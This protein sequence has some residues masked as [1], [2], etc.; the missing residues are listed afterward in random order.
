LRLALGWR[1]GARRLSVVVAIA[2]WAASQPACPSPELPAV[3]RGQRRRRA[4]LR[5]VVPFGNLLSGQ[6]TPGDDQRERRA[7]LGHRAGRV[8]AAGVP[9]C[10]RAAVRAR[11]ARVR[12][13][14]AFALRLGLAVLGLIVVEQLYRR[15]DR[16]AR[17]ALK[18]LC[19]AVAGIFAFDLYYFADAMLFGRLDIDIWMG[20]GL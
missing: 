12:R 10:P 17:W 1:A 18:P 5:D 15:A 11:R 2:L 20:H 14:A 19:V 8:R 16:S 6:T 4:A 7:A 3:V 9:P 13:T